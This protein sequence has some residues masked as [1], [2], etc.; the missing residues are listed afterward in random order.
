M[1]SEVERRSF[2]N[3][4]EV[5]SINKPEISF[6]SH[7]INHPILTN[8]QADVIEDEICKSK[9]ILEKETGRDVVHFCY[10]NGD[11]NDEI[12]MIASGSYKSACTTRAGFVSKDSDIYALN[13]IG[14][15]EEMVTDWRGNFSKYVFTLSLFLES[16]RQ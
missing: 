16:V 3:W 6:G 4:D 1:T 2:I 14:I 9:E 8:E 11:Y 5:R 10:P 12:R 13:R 7:T 15:N